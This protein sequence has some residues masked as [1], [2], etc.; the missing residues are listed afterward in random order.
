MLLLSFAA[1]VHQ[2]TA[3][4]F[5]G[6]QT[7]KVTG[8]ASIGTGYLQVVSPQGHLFNP[9]HPFILHY[10]L[11]FFDSYFDQVSTNNYQKLYL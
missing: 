3:R 1:S 2:T 10:F 6:C 8:D 11:P 7:G 9:F 5:E 4:T